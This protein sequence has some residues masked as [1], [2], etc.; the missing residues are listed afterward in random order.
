[1]YYVSR[2]DV[3]LFIMRAERMFIYVLCEQKGCLSMY[4]VSRKDVYLC[5]MSA[6]RYIKKNEFILTR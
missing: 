3:Y 5:V 4:Y 6:V 1:M 2:K